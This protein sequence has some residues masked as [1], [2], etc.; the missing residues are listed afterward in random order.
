LCLAPVRLGRLA[1][2]QAQTGQFVPGMIL[3]FGAWHE[4]NDLCQAPL[5]V[6][7]LASIS[8]IVPGTI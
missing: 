8:G 3:L 2:C 1:G 6:P 7:Y 4:W 5:I